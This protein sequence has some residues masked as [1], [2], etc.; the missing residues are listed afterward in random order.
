MRQL[1]RNKGA[2]ISLI[3]L[4]VVVFVALAAPAIAPFDPEEVA[5][6]DRLM[7]PSPTHFFGTDQFGRD[8]FSRTLY[9]T[10]IT[11]M[12]ALTAVLL[13]TVTGVIPGLIAGYVGGMLD[14]VIM[15]LVDI[16]LAF[17]GILLA[18][19]VVAVLGVGLNQ[20]IWAIAISYIP[21]YIRLVRGSVIATKEKVYIEAARQMGCTTLRICFRH[22]LPNVFFPVMVTSTTAIAWAILAGSALNFIG[23]GVPPPIAEWGADMADGRNYLRTAWWIMGGPG[24]A[25]MT[26]IY[27]VNLLGDWLA[28]TMDPRLRQR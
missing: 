18:L 9:G 6:T 1:F 10:R 26:T 12:F 20:L 14:T 25:I 16:M 19:V 11:L 27:S 22:I 5:V 3:A 21:A 28:F 23:L 24:L 4:L 15:R 17:P 7:P 8:V 2:T 13:S